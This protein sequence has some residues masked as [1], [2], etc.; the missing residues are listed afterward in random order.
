MKALA[1]PVVVDSPL[2]AAEQT[3]S[4]LTSRDGTPVALQHMTACLKKLSIFSD[5][6]SNACKIVENLSF[7]YPSG[8]R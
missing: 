2:E 8:A 7:C 1:S 3:L 6:L 4:P 5:K